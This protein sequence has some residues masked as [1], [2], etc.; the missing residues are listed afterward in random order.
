MT[1]EEAK[2]KW[3][4][5]ARCL[6]YADDAEGDESA[7]SFNREYEGKGAPGAFCIASQCMAWRWQDGSHFDPTRN[8]WVVDYGQHGKGLA[9]G[10][11]GLAGV[12]R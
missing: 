8:A 3:C 5:F 12:P 7:C 10:Y 2:T 6:G 9:R 1:E 4:P 11:C